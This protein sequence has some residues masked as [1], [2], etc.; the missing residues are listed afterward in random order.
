MSKIT[1]VPVDLDLANVQPSL[2]K[3]ARTNLASPK[4]IKGAFKAMEILASVNNF[5]KKF[6]QANSQRILALLLRICHDEAKGSFHHFRK[7]FQLIL[8]RCPDA[9]NIMFEP[10]VESF[11]Q[12]PIL[13]IL[14]CIV[15]SPVQDVLISYFVKANSKVSLAQKESLSN[16][17]HSPF[18]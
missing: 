4:E 8:L 14:S 15:N 9:I 11:G 12:P 16:G 17:L 13:S 7:I 1:L 18:A 2:Q 3:K 6:F 10:C 5:S